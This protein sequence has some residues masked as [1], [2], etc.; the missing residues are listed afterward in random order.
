MRGTWYLA[1]GLGERGESSLLADRMD[2]D[3]FLVVP[4]SGAASCVARG[5]AEQVV[6]SVTRL[7]GRVWRVATVREALV[8][9]RVGETGHGEVELLSDT[10]PAEV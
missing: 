5:D 3:F 4:L 8:V 2:V 1:D 9:V 7:E 6:E 10:H